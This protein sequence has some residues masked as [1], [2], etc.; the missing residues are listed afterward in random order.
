M[1]LHKFPPVR[2]IPTF[3]FS[4]QP[5]RGFR[6]PIS[7]RN[8]AVFNCKRDALLL[9]IKQLLAHNVYQILTLYCL[10]DAAS[11]I[12]SMAFDQGPPNAFLT[13]G[14]PLA[15]LSVTDTTQKI[16]LLSVVPL[17]FPW[18]SADFSIRFLSATVECK[19]N[20]FKVPQP[21]HVK[22]LLPHGSTQ[23]ECPPSA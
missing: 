18:E 19:T 22:S 2:Q 23:L 21:T 12:G 16:S 15:L 13:I 10:E 17:L 20:G 5:L 11:H 3:T 4:R 7:Q 8:K 6:V 9:Y 14:Q 1:W